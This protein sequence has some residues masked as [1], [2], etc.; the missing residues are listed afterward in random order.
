MAFDPQ[1][2]TQ[3][4]A[5]QKAAA[6]D[7]APQ[8]R[9]VAGPGSGKSFSIEGRVEHLLKSNVPVARVLAVSFTRNASKDLE[10]RIKK[11]CVQSGL[12]QLGNVSVGTLH[13]VAL[14]ALR[15]ASL[16]NMYP[17]DPRVLDD[18]EMQEWIDKEFGRY[19]R[20]TPGRA[21]DVREFHEAWWSTGQQN[22]ANYIPADP[23][24]TAQ[25]Q[26]DFVT[27]HNMQTGFYACL[28][29]GEIVRSCMQHAK[30]NAIDLRGLLGIDHLIVDEYQDLNPMDLDF[31]DH[32]IGQGV[33]TFAAGDDDQS[34]YSFRHASP[35]GIQTFLQRFPSAGKHMLSECFRCTPAVL[36]AAI[37]VLASFSP[38]GRI[39][40]QLSSLY[41]TASPIV[42]GH[43]RWWKFSTPQAE[44]SA[45]AQSCMNLNSAGVNYGEIMILLGNRSVL[46]KTIQDE[47]GA[48]G[49]PF[50]P[51]QVEP[52][53]D[54]PGGRVGFSFLRILADPNDL[55]AHRDVLSLIPQMGPGRCFDVTLRCRNANLN[56]LDLY[57]GH[58]PN[59]V[60]T[61][62]QLSN[63]NLV[64][65]I[66]STIQMWNVDDT[67]AQRGSSLAQ[68]IE[69]VRGPADRQEWDA[70]IQTIPQDAT[71]GE[72]CDLLFVDNLEDSG[73]VL[74]TIHER[75]GL[76]VP[77]TVNSDRVQILTMHGA[78]G[79]S[80]KVVFIP[81][82]EETIFPNKRRAAKPGLVDEG[83]RLAYVSITR[84][85]AAVFLSGTHG[86]TQNG[87]YVQN[88]V[89]RYLPHSGLTMQY[90]QQ[91]TG[92]DTQFAQAIAATCNLL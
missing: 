66:T 50:S 92:I 61:P 44:A 36:N 59:G 4:T 46:A 24:I 42:Q 83:A 35:Q 58:I 6:Q 78:K 17:V 91:P 67:V 71:L 48:K 10:T 88:P 60:L 14:R 65:A 8:V 20:V 49:V 77:S 68:F 31:V 28:F 30:A 84:A 21:K 74:T 19:A 86:R 81:G 69:Q 57:Q 72:V 23:P 5:R 7:S 82:L 32:L 34:V 1:L 22:P 16:L 43:A 12:H 33:N 26:Q 89:S 40:K 18:W 47:L 39:P 11:M 55:V 3:A 85:R 70:F 79:L 73:A 29:V 45:I 2:V 63:V 27:Y 64:R 9:L 54:R 90:Q 53:R 25:E 75:L 13:S 51:I 41:A 15:L 87:S 56:A 38:P 37:S 52:F 76:P 62:M 80:S